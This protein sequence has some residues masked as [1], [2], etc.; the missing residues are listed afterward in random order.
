MEAD[1]KAG[2]R[3]THDNNLLSDVQL[4]DMADHSLGHYE[5][6]H[7][8]EARPPAPAERILMN[9][10]ATIRRCKRL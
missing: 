2:H 8:A 4:E 10:P 7:G 6:I 1:G 9:V 3:S 5:S